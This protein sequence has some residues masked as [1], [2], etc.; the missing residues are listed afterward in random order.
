MTHGSRCVG[1]IQQSKT[2]CSRAVVWRGLGWE[3][4]APVPLDDW[5]KGKWA[6]IQ[7]DGETPMIFPSSVPVQTCV[8]CWDTVF[9]CGCGSSVGSGGVVQRWKTSASCDHSPYW[10]MKVLA[11]ACKPLKCWSSKCSW[12][13]SQPVRDGLSG[14]KLN[15][16]WR[17]PREWLRGLGS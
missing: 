4:L 2:R 15:P 16:E 14:H 13:L 10:S 11:D 12:L 7:R 1:V 9:C 3:L 6:G 8:F 5:K 17:R